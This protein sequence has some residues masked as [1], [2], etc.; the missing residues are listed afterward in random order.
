MSRDWRKK[1]GAASRENSD[2]SRLASSRHQRHTHAYCR[3][4]KVEEEEEMPIIG[5]V[6]GMGGRKKKRRRGEE[7][8][9]WIDCIPRD[10]LRLR[11]FLQLLCLFTEGEKKGQHATQPTTSRRRRQRREE[12][13]NLFFSLV[14]SLTERQKIDQTGGCRNCPALL[15]VSDVTVLSKKRQ[16]GEAKRSLSTVSAF[17]QHTQEEK[18]SKALV[19]LRAPRIN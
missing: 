7:A 12:E 19:L 18:D 3:R 11:S 5:L 4:D 15:L 8:D 6:T 13:E 14:T 16:L 1:E 10:S 9:R 17:P 2:R